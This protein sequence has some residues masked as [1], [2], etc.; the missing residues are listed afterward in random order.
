M[1]ENLLKNL[2]SDL[3]PFKSVERLSP[4]LMKRLIPVFSL[5]VAL[6]FFMA[7]KNSVLSMRWSDSLF[8]LENTIWVF[9]TFGSFAAFYFSAFPQAQLKM[10][11]RLIFS[12]IVGLFL[13]QV[14]QVNYSQIYQEFILELNPLRGGCGLVISAM[15]IG[16]WWALQKW[17]SKAAPRSPKMTGL[18]A[19]L[20]ASSAGCLLMQA[21]CFHEGSLHLMMWHFLPLALSCYFGPLAAKKF[22]RW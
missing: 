15:A 21:V 18:W 2:A 11:D 5:F 4:F 1:N 3:K 6:S 13:L 8:F 20:S 19:S 17:A 16:Y 14:T 12:G 7:S 9:V 22:L 10:A